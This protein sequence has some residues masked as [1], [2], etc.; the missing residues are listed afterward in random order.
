MAA[1][2]V[3]SV[4]G[5]NFQ[6][7]GQFLARSNA[8]IYLN[9]AVRLLHIFL[10]LHAP[11]C[12][13]I[14][15]RVSEIHKSISLSGKTVGFLKMTNTKHTSPF[16]TTRKCQGTLLTTYEGVRSGVKEPG[17]SSISYNS[18]VIK[19]EGGVAGEKE[20]MV[21]IFS[22]DRKDGEWL[23]CVFGV[24]KVGW[25]LRKEWD[26]YPKLSPRM[27]FPPVQID[28]GLWYVNSLELWV[29]TME[30]QT[31][32]SRNIVE[33]IFQGDFG[34]DLCGQMLNGTTLSK[35]AQEGG[36]RSKEWEGEGAN[37]KIWGW[38]C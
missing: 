34:E 37:D 16:R 8:S 26:S 1:S 30:T 10:F 2:G 36:R 12:Q 21:Q 27:N 38:D 6:I 24:G 4:I 35:H 20:W 23:E 29:S 17:F 11:K 19:R 5:G 32:S 15:S 14:M 3:S 13:L 33:L 9:T 25:V 7:F 31:L 18:E 28:S 22:T